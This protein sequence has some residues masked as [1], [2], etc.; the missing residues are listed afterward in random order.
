[1]SDP[2]LV[3]PASKVTLQVIAFGEDQKLLAGST[4]DGQA[5]FIQEGE[6]RRW[7][8]VDAPGDTGVAFKLEVPDALFRAVVYG[9][10]QP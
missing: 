2:I 1:M 7:I 6:V 5:C 3:D 10:G 9:W 8:V 4:G